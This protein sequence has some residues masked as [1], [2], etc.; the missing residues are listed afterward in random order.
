MDKKTILKECLTCGKLFH[1]RICDVK[2]GGGKYCSRECYFKT[3]G[4]NQ[5]G[6]YNPNYKCKI[7]MT[8]I[9]CGNTFFRYPSR[10]DQKYCSQACYH[11]NRGKRQTGENNPFWKGGPVTVTCQYCG[12]EFT[13]YPSSIENYHAGKYCS[14]ECRNADKRGENCHFWDGGISTEKDLF[15]NSAIWKHKRNEIFKRDEGRCKICG[16]K[17]K[18]D[19]TY[20][21]HHIVGFKCEELRL[22]NANL[23]LTCYNCHNWIHSTDNTER[24]YIMSKDEFLAQNPEYPLNTLTP[25]LDEG[26][27]ITE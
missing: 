25:Y 6:K 9:E 19:E 10:I 2:N 20:R 7:E 1:A 27:A 16:H 3:I 22:V 24:E 12:N 21:I 23:I 11:K 8:C 17:F 18:P 13:E 15:T 4:T 14:N 26:E 5:R